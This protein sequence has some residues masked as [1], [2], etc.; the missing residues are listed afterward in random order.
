MAAS[1][2]LPTRLWHFSS[3]WKSCDC[4]LTAPSVPHIMLRRMWRR[5]LAAFMSV[6]SLKSSQSNSP[7]FVTRH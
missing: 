7:L 6:P 2:R 4:N 5:L 3:D 1:Q